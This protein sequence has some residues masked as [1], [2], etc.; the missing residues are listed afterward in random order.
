MNTQELITNEIIA[1][2]RLVATDLDIWLYEDDKAAS[3]SVMF[4]VTQF[5][6]NAETFSI[7]HLNVVIREEKKGS[8]VA[9]RVNRAL[10]NI[11]QFN[12]EDIKVFGLSNT[13]VKKLGYTANNQSVESLIM[14]KVYFVQ[15]Q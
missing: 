14:C 9:V 4:W 15:Q 7:L 10:Q 11:S 5:E 2:L 8:E 3:P 6:E 1:K 12:I 13:G